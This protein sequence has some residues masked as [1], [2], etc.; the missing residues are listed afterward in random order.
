MIER[1]DLSAQDREL[2]RDRA[3][4]R[5]LLL[6]GVLALLPVAAIVVI[7]VVFFS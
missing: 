2:A 6:Y 1:R 7:R 5:W 3:R 4:E